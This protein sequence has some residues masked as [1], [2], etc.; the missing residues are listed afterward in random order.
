MGGER[1]GRKHSAERLL[2]YA[3]EFDGSGHVAFAF[4]GTVHL[5]VTAATPSNADA[6][7]TPL[8]FDTSYYAILNTAVGGPWPAPPS[9]STVFPTDHFVDYVRVAQPAAA[10]AATGG[11]SVGAVAAAAAAA[12]EVASATAAATT[13]V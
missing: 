7:P 1:G 8:F 6:A 3:A 12:A 2:R 11:S 9:A 4:D 13:V 5:N 10:A